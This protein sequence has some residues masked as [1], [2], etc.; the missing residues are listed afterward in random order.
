MSIAGGPD[1]MLSEVADV[2]SSVSKRVSSE[3]EVLV[4]T[5]VDPDW[6]EGMLISLYSGVVRHQQT[7]QSN[8]V[9]PAAGSRRR[10]KAEQMQ[11]KLRFTSS[12]KGRFKDVEATIMDGEDLDVPTFIRRGLNIDK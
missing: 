5:N 8:D 11:A 7:A 10:K 3:C 12:A 9:R 4:G 1:L 2:V 6:K